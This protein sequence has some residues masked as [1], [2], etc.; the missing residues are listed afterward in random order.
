MRA[1]AASTGYTLCPFMEIPSADELTLIYADTTCTKVL[2]GTVA[3]D[4]PDCTVTYDSIATEIIA[5]ITT[6]R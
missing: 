4:L 6:A 5:D 3:L 2:A 1:C